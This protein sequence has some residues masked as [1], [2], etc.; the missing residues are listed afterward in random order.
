VIELK[1]SS[2]NLVKLKFAVINDSD[3]DLTLTDGYIGTNRHG[4]EYA[5]VAG[6]T[7]LDEAGKKKYFI[8]RDTEDTPVCSIAIENVKAHTRSQFWASYPAPPATVQQI[9]VMIPHFEPMTK[10]PLS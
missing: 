3:Q 2:D 6:I 7:L 5:S 10:V 1:H 9:T 4:N 8:V